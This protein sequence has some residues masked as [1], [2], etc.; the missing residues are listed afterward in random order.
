[1]AMTTPRPRTQPRL[2]T[3]QRLSEELGLPYT[4]ARDLVIRGFLPK[5]TLG[6][7]TRIWVRREDVERMLA[8]VQ[9]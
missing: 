2:L 1:M 4:S 7:S 9:E 8:Q 5:V 6:D 3:L